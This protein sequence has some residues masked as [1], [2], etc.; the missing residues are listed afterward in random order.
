MR[1]LIE[2]IG[3]QEKRDK[4]NHIYYKTLAMIDDGTECWGWG[5]DFQIGD[6]VEV[7]FHHDEIKMRKPIDSSKSK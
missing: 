6:Q 1:T 3:T 2:I 4:D 7:F 5:S